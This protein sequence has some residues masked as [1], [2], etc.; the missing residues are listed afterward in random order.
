[1]LKRM[2]AVSALC[3]VLTGSSA[4]ADVSAVFPPSSKP[5]G[6]SYSTWAERWGKYAFGFPNGENPLIFASDCS[7][8]LQAHGGAWLLPASGGGK[9]VV[10][11]PVE[12]NQPLLLTPGGNQGVV[13]INGKD[14]AAT[15]Q[16]VRESM[17]GT[18]S[19]FV[20]IDGDRVPTIGQFRTH[21]GF[22]NIYIH[23]HNIV[24]AT[25]PGTYQMKIAGWFVML[26]ALAP[27]DHTI[28]A[29]DVFPSSSGP[30]SATTRYKLH[31]G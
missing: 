13:G 9:Q 6:D 22:F 7:I 25:Q 23:K 21:T 12:A 11:C 24:G 8:S 16:Y 26:R 18:D 10:D 28:I 17:R 3:L 5:L 31:V 15:R 2:L 14:R 27:G 29:H 20:S 1:M 30:V 4:S 19:L